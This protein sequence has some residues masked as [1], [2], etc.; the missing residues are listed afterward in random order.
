MLAEQPHLSA[1][2]APED[3]SGAGVLHPVVQPQCSLAV[4]L[5]RV[6]ESVVGRPAE[7]GAIRQE[8]KAAETH[9]VALTMEGEPGI[10]KTRLLVAAAEMAETSGFLPVAVTTDEQIRGPFLLAQSI[11]A[12]PVIR[13]AVAGSG[14]ERDVQR[15]VDA[16][17]GRDEPGLETLSSDSRLVRAYDLAAVAL[18]AVSSHTPLALLIDDLQWAD[19][20][21]LRML[22]YAIRADAE[23]SIF[24]YL[25]LRPDELATV[26]E[27]VTLLADMERMG[28][29]RRLKLARFTQQETAELLRQVL[30]APIDPQSAATMHAQSEGVPF[31]V[32][33]LARAYREAGMIQQINDTWVLARNAGRLVPSAV[34]T[35]IQRRAG[36]LPEDAL[37]A[38]ADA[39]VLGRSFS[40]RDLAAI[41]QAVGGREA[42]STPA[43]VA[44]A[45]SPAVVAGLL[46]EH[47]ADEPADYTFTHEQVREFASAELPAARR[48]A[49]HGAVVDLLVGDGEPPPGSLALLARHALEA[50]DEARAAAFSR[51]AARAALDANAPEEALRVVDQAL[52]SASSSADRLVLLTARDDALAMLRRSNDRLEGLA[53]LA[54]LTE[55]LGDGQRELEVMLRRAAALRLTE[56]DDTAAELARRVRKL[57]RER[58]DEASELRRLPGAGPGPHAHRAR[59]V[60]QPHGERGRPGRH[61]GGPHGGNGARRAAGGRREPGRRHPGARHDGDVARPHLVRGAGPGRPHDRVH[62]RGDERTARGHYPHLEIADLIATARAQFERALGL[63]ERLGDRRGVM[64]TVIAMAYLSYA[65]EIHLTSSARYIEEIRRVSDRM[66]GLVRES[67]RALA[68]MQM[69]YGVHVYA[70]AKV[71]PDLAISRG[72]QAYRSAKVLGDRSIEFRAAGG[73]A[74]T[75]LEM[76][77][78]EAAGT[79]L[80]RAAAAALAAPTPGRARQLEM[81]RGIVRGALGEAGGGDADPPRAGRED[82]HRR[83][84]A[85][86]PLRGPGPPGARGRAAR[87]CLRGP[88]PPPARRAGRR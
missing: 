67:E 83:R 41:R 24:V 54:A 19:D 34:R 23:S 47:G 32:E 25:A 20:D 60:V 43:E 42:E 18:S 49:M 17:S 78:L 28:L 50:G 11:F 75:H 74:M 46:I 48:R 58:G 80:D 37:A 30:A 71:V 84:S 70:R 14:A 61:R 65:P 72:E 73:L 15:A 36:R 81:W 77:E 27:A 4:Q 45:L 12:S 51:D 2:V 7:L 35:L 3:L 57:A 66:F 44:E 79:W 76:G 5:R 52:A 39:S 22:R 53:E 10:G 38:M 85:R 33:E 40:V 13:E 9:L 6:T 16:I 64:S 56:D 55:A 63:Y 31:I 87:R 62:G 88:R 59:R 21:S 8:L 1:D 29:V 26:N 68:E 82:G 86:R 69:E